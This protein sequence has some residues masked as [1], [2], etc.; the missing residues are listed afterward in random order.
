MQVARGA[1][2]LQ[3]IV[4]TESA[5]EAEGQK[6]AEENESED[7]PGEDHED[8]VSEALKRAGERRVGG[9]HEP[10]EK[11][12]QRGNDRA[13][14]GNVSRFPIPKAARDEHGDGSL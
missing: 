9:W 2:A 5:P 13:G 8:D 1:A 3:G 4:S 14:G 10:R 12:E 7:G 6:D 11:R